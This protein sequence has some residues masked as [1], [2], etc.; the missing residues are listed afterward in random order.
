MGAKG[1]KVMSAKV[2][3]A[4]P[5]QRAAR[6]KKR[7]NAEAAKL[8]EQQTAA[9][10]PPDPVSAIRFRQQNQAEVDAIKARAGR[11]LRE[12]TATHDERPLRR[13]GYW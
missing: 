9:A 5:G 13:S 11:H 8:L 4:H 1:I 6:E 7:K 2:A 10:N 12:F 3:R